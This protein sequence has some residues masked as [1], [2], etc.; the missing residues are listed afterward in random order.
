[1]FWKK[2]NKDKDEGKLFKAPPADRGAFRVYPSKENPV[3][4]KVG[5]TDLTASDISAGG[6]SFDNNNFKLGATYP[7]ELNLPKGKG[8]FN[9]QTEVLKIDDQNVCR[10]KILGLSP[11]QEDVIHSYILDRQKEEIAEKKNKNL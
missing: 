1:L 7:M 5:E 9:L 10:C 6:I 4:L 8:T 11:E 3:K 2:K